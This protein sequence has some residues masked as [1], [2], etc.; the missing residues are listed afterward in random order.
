MAWYPVY[1]IPDAPLTARFLTFHTIAPQQ[2]PLLEAVA[3]A[4]TA[5]PEGQP[6]PPPPPRQLF[7]P[8]QGANMFAVI[9]S[10]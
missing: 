4:E 2:L 9:H 5:P 10:R 1:R 3:G 8:V 7:M 6:A